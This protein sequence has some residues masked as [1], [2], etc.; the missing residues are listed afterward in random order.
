MFLASKNCSSDETVLAGTLSGDQTSPGF[1]IVPDVFGRLTPLDVA[2][3]PGS[4][5]G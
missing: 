5:A 2:K 4:N 1:T 3:P